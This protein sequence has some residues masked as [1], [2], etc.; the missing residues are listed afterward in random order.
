MRFFDFSFFLPNSSLFTILCRGSFLSFHRNFTKLT[1]YMPQPFSFMPTIFCWDQ[2]NSF[3]D[4]WIFRFFA[5]ICPNSSFLQKKNSNLC[6]SGLCYRTTVLKYLNYPTCPHATIVFTHTQ[7]NKQTHGHFFEIRVFRQG[8][9]SSG[10]ILMKLSE[11]MRTV[12]RKVLT[13]FG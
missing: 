9:R 2:N 6:G 8:G 5:Q 3:W 13:K 1:H 4:F 12:I 10:R 11:K 7:T